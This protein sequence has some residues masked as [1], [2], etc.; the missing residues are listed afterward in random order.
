MRASENYVRYFRSLEERL[1]VL[2]L[3]TIARSNSSQTSKLTFLTSKNQL[4]FFLYQNVAT[5]IKKTVFPVLSLNPV[6][7]KG[8]NPISCLHVLFG[9]FSIKIAVTFGTTSFNWSC[10]FGKWQARF[11]SQKIS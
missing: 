4:L 11:Q 3:K 10:H 9:F 5:K 2:T 7:H 6:S 1:F 8:L